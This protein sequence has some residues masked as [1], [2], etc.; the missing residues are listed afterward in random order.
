MS[1][2]EMQAGRE[3]DALVAEKVMGARYSVPRYSA[4][5]AAA[6]EV[7]ERMREHPDPRFRTLRMVAYPYN[8]TYATFDAENED[9]WTEANGENATPLAICRAALA[10]LEAA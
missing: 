5:I 8:R 2:T 6:W 7:V 4:D 1:T 10:A 9:E 3:M